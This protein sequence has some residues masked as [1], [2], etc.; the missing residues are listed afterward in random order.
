MRVFIGRSKQIFASTCSDEHV[1][2]RMP[3]IVAYQTTGF[4]AMVDLRMKWVTPT[5]TM[6]P[7]LSKLDM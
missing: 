1:L 7:S 6:V 5:R 4:I 3:H 2:K